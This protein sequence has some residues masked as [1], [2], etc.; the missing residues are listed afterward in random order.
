MASD[1]EPRVYSVEEAAEVLRIG[2]TAAYDAVRRGEIPAVRIGRSL[3]IPCDALT[4][5]LAPEDGDGPATTRAAA[6]DRLME[7]RHGEE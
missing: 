6:E 2:R 7:S 5:L 3:R 1:C 4:R